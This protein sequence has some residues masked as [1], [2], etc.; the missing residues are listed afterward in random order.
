MKK[1]IISFVLTFALASCAS[2][3]VDT[4]KVADAQ[5]VEKKTK[6]KKDYRDCKKKSTGSRTRRC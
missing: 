5:K 4:M 1:I 3:D 6:E 2:Q